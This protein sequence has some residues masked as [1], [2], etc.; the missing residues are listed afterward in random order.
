MKIEDEEQIGEKIPWKDRKRRQ[1]TKKEEI[2][3]EKS[4]P[5]LQLKFEAQSLDQQLQQRSVWRQEKKKTLG[6]TGNGKRERNVQA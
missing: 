5:P 6:N 2:E 4:K 3:G 1:K